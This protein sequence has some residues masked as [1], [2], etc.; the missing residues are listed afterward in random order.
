MAK[1]DLQFAGEF[2]VQQCK[3]MTTN[4]TT[5]DIRQLVQSINIYEDIFSTAVSGDI[6]IKDTNN[7]I[8]NGP[9]I[10]EEKLILKILTPQKNPNQDTTI[11]YTETPLNVYRVNLVTG[12]GENALLYSLNFT[13]QEAMRNQVSRVSQSYKGQPSDIVEKILR[14]KNYLDSTRRYFAEET[15]NHTK[16]VFP[17]LKPFM[18]INH[19]TKIS[20][21]KQY[22]QSP[23]YLFYETTRGFHFRS[24][25]G[26]ASQETKWEYEENIPNS[27]GEKGTVDVEKNLH[28]MN[29]F[30][31]MPTRD[32][33][34]NMS[35]GFYS[36]KL[37]VHNIYSKTLKDVDFNYL[38]NFTNDIHTDGTSKPIITE[39]IDSQT[40]KRL[41]DHSE[42]KLFV[43]TTS[44]GKHFY[45]SQDYPYQS[46]N[47]DNTLQRRTSRLRQIDK[48][49]KVQLSAAGHTMLQAGDIIQLKVGATSANTTEKY[50]M[51]HSGRYILTTLRHEFNLTAD[52]RH[53]LYMEAC[54]DSVVDALPSSGVQY[55]NNGSAERI[56][57]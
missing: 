15:A 34:Y 31:V 4:G 12:A 19:L 13:T 49:I 5:Y 51:H 52:P 55:Q 46:D 23:A 44:G 37:R 39:S 16:I 33:I 9:I 56:T 8:M 26:L 21:S 29:T 27:L 53:K 20:N 50:D 28:T 54:K 43:S 24:I 32:T 40:G 57:L 6:T 30:S 22:N 41:S 14:D 11:D 25:D 47:L 10:G 7:M 18:C 1:S 45:E 36:S 38:D 42:T 3:L 2:L 35:E 48:G 17:N